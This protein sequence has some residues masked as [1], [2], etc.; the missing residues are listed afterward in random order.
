MSIDDFE[1]VAVWLAEK[2]FTK[3][4]EWVAENADLGFTHFMKVRVQ[5][6]LKLQKSAIPDMFVILDDF[7]CRSAWS[8]DPE[9]HLI[10]CITSLMF[11]LEYK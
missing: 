2:V 3:L 5:L 6:E 9:I 7:D 1:Q 11:D 10:A 8:T 4:R